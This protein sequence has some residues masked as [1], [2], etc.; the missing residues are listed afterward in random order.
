M[1][2]KRSCLTGLL[3]LASAGSALAQERIPASTEFAGRIVG[4]VTSLKTG[5]AVPLA[6]VALLPLKG[7]IPHPAPAVVAD[8]S[9]RFSFERVQP[10]GYVLT[11][12]G[13]GTGEAQ[14]LANVVPGGATSIDVAL[15]PIG[16]VLAE[17]MKQ[18]E[19]LSEARNTWMFEGPMTY[20][21]TLRSECF[22]FGVNPLW[23]LEEQADS[24]IVLNS[25]PGVPMEVPAQFAGM[26]RIFA[27]IEA[28]IRDTGRR[29]EVR[30][31]QSL[32]YPEHIRFDTLEMLSDSWQTITIRD[33]KEVRQ[34]E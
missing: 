16:Y 9:G 25:G 23:V 8:S 30:Y 19:E 11:A 27:W 14:L 21:F 3:L 13:M 18:L 1:N 32:G 26:E 20:Q 2:L 5:A 28:E 34:R 33:V 7:E 24:I 29:V 22:C 12:R 4:T 17:R 6:R 10:G 31:N 15:P